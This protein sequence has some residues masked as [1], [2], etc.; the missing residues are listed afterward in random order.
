MSGS[1]R[2][3]GALGPGSQDSPCVVGETQGSS[4][5]NLGVC[6]GLAGPRLVWGQ[7]GPRR[8]RDGGAQPEGPGLEWLGGVRGRPGP[9]ARSRELTVS[10]GG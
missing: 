9:P 1:V 4:L 3:A 10:P 8:V 5:E 2:V 6:G 7:Q